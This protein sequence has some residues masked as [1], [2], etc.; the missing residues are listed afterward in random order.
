VFERYYRELLNFCARLTRDRD[1]AADA[2]QESYARV[3][4][5]ERSSVPIH[6]PRALLYQ[7]A[8]H[9]LVDQH[10]R[11]L[12]RAHEA[13]DATGQPEP[14]APDAQDPQAQAISAQAVQAYVA[15]IEALPPRCREAFVLHVFDGLSHAE[16]AAR[17]GASV[18][19]VEKHIARGRL[20]CRACERALQGLAP[21]PP[22][23]ARPGVRR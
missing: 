21:E 6:A 16:I 15:T 3:L 8:R 10:R 11:A 12:L 20:A 9:V 14:A 22:P 18:S 4:A 2:V 19:M 7:T 1:A 23:Q 13:L 17:M 5:I